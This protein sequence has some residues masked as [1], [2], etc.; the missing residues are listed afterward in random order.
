MSET[1]GTPDALVRRS[2]VLVVVAVVVILWVW[3]S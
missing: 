1:T 3:K 2:T